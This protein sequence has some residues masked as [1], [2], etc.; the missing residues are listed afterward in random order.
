M[1]D[2]E[3]R[4][5]KLQDQIIDMQKNMM[6]N[7]NNAS[8]SVTRGVVTAPGSAA[9]T[10]ATERL[11]SLFA[12]DSE[13]VSSV[14]LPSIYPNGSPKGNSSTTATA[15]ATAAATNTPATTS[16]DAARRPSRIPSATRRRSADARSRCKSRLDRPLSSNAAQEKTVE[17]LKVEIQVCEGEE[18][19]GRACMAY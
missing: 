1:A 12:S 17:E 8:S 18:M 4:I 2:R 19:F 14:T 15:T 5:T 3:Q 6:M 7:Q 13:V 11:G 10:A 9:S 16:A